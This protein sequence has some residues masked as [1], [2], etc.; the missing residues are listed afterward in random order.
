MVGLEIERRGRPESAKVSI[1]QCGKQFVNPAH[2]GH[3]QFRGQRIQGHED[4]GT[5]GKVGM[6][7]NQVVLLENSLAVD[8]QIKIDDP[9][10]PAP[11]FAATAQSALNV[12]QQGQQLSGIQRGI[13][14]GNRIEKVR[15]VSHPPGRGHPGGGYTGDVH[16]LGAIEALKRSRQC[17]RR[18]TLIG[19]EPDPAAGQD[20]A[21]RL[22]GR[23]RLRLP[24]GETIWWRSSGSTS[25][26][27][28]HQSASSCSSGFSMAR[29][30]R[31]S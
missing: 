3:D 7:D 1:V 11:A 27:V 24:S 25:W 5:L 9:R 21:F 30:R 15:L 2:A 23:L 8:E 4:K 28:V 16:A 31:K 12:K 10:T 18:I 22:R 20:A 14:S 19:T 17:G 29:S 6:R 13:D 26:M